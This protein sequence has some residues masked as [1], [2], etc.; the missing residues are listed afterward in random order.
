MSV[1]ETTPNPLPMT[2]TKRDLVIRISNETGLIQQQVLD[3]VQ[4]TLD[5]IAEALAKGDKVE[6]RN[7]GV[8][9]VKVRKARIGRNPNSPETDVPIPERSV[10]KFKPG[11][12]MRAEVFKIEPRDDAPEPAAGQ[13]STEPRPPAQS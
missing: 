10:V 3:V 9:E 12:E 5:Y 6:L 4:K 13:Q 2:L 11:K 7:F 1:R 8:F